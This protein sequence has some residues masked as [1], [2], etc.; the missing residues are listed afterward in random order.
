M[1]ER[2]ATVNVSQRRRFM[3]NTRSLTACAS[4]ATNCGQNRASFRD[5]EAV[6]RRLQARVRL[7]QTASHRPLSSLDVK[8]QDGVHE[9]TPAIHMEDLAGNIARFIIA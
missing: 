9:R 5:A 4:A 6:R 3:A 7:R 8:R 1:A 2:A